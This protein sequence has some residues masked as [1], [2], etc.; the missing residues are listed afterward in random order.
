MMIRHVLFQRIQCA[1]LLW[2]F[3]MGNFSV[4]EICD[5]Y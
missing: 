5:K 3:N 4:T 2:A 1:P